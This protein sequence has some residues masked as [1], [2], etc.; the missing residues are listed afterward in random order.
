V[1]IPGLYATATREQLDLTVKQVHDRGSQ[2]IGLQVDVRDEAQV[3]ASVKEAIDNFGQIDVLVNNAG[4]SSSAMLHDMTEEAWDLV[5]D[6]SLKGQAL[7]CKHVIPGM[8]GRRGGRIVNISS[9]VIGS[10]MTMISHYVA[11]KHGVVGLT[12]ALATELG[13]FGINANSIAPGTIR[14]TDE[15]GSGMVRGVAAEFG[16]GSAEEMYEMASAQYNMAGDKWRVE[17]QGI[18]DAVLFLA[19]QRAHDHRRGVARQRGSNDKVTARTLDGTLLPDDP[20][21]IA[22]RSGM[23]NG[24]KPGAQGP[25]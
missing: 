6:I 5:V 10:G 8:I 18:T 15:H 2:G 13:E 7:T 25:R 16:V 9:A 17:M 11:A 19:G 21:A 24:G 4:M 23:T 3:K 20:D 1:P 22:G 14:P 12:K